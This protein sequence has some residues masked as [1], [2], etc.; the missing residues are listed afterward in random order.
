MKNDPNLQR[1]FTN[2]NHIVKLSQNQPP[3]PSISLDKSSK[4]LEN[5]KK[6]V[7]DFYSITALHYLRDLY[8]DKWND[9]QADTQYLGAGSS[10][11]LASLLVTEVLQHSLYTTNRP[12]FMLALDAKSAIDRCLCQILC[13]VLYKAGV[14]GSAILFMDSRLASRQTVY[15]WEGVKM[16]PASD[17]T[18]FEQGG[19]N[20]GD[21]Y[22]LYNNDQLTT[23]QS[24]C[25]VAD[26][27]SE[28]ISGVGDADDVLLLSNDINDLHLLVMMTEKYCQKYRVKLE[29]KKTKLLGYSNTLEI[30]S[31]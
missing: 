14:A 16:G 11:E 1:Q 24:S 25:L 30:T 13:C 8:I 27:G 6:N 17:T 31:L 3:I 19:I 26:V 21:Y 28:V 12:V 15:E 9:F 29:P 22:K 4:I 7:N 23:A 5:L 2:Y 10:H 20:S 18:G